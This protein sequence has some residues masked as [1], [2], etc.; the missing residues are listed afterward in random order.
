M[1]MLRESLEKVLT[2]TDLTSEEMA[3]AMEAIMEGR[4][5]EVQ[6]AAFL[7]ALRV[8]G[9][10]VVEI[11][12]AARVMREKA[13]QVEVDRHPL[14]DIVGTGGDGTGTFNISTA[15]ALVVAATGVAV[16]KHGNRSVSS[17]CGS[18]DVLEALGIPLLA[19]PAD[20][21]DCVETT[22]FG[23]LFAPHFHRAMK[24]VVPIRKCL[25]LRT[26][27]N[28]L[29]PLTNP[30]RPDCQLM[31]VFA[32]ELVRPMAEVLGG[33]GVKRAL[34]V[35]GHGGMDELS[36]SGPNKVSF[37]KDGVVADLEISP[38][39]AGLSCAGAGYAAGGTPEDN[40]RII[41]SVFDGERGPRR[42]VVVFNAAAALL[43]A[44]RVDSLELG[45]RMAEEVI[46]AGLAA[47]KQAEVAAFAASR[48]EGVA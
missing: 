41:E 18:A 3:G 44:G 20:V 36:L 1:S 10:T 2:R 4:V 27:F 17:K 35:H 45:A 9:E 43:T 33:L 15:T 28:V 29:G 23:F 46:E 37:L 8:K 47:A 34:V 42:D 13:L 31:G 32:P 40:R 24:N 7:A 19:G 30:A 21:A 39:N 14:L 12:E 11:T 16:A 26:I 22:G 5:P 38:E 48:Q 6:V 25:G